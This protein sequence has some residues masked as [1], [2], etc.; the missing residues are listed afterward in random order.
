MTARR[1]VHPLKCGLV[2][3]WRLPDYVEVSPNP[4]P[5]GVVLGWVVRGAPDCWVAIANDTERGTERGT[6]ATAPAAAELLLERE[7]R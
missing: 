5:H 1:T 2:L 3:D 7:G 6:A 4:N